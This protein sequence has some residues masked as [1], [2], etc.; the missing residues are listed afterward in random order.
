MGVFPQDHE[1]SPNT[2]RLFAICLHRCPQ[3]ITQ[4]A[5]VRNRGFHTSTTPYYNY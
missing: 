3:R 5:T 1:L 2:R 4:P